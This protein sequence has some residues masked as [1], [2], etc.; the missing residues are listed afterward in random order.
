MIHL[1][2]LKDTLPM[3]IPQQSLE[4]VVQ[5]FQ[6]NNI[7]VFAQSL[8]NP[9][10]A[11]L[12]SR[13]WFQ[14]LY[15]TDREPSW[16]TIYLPNQRT[17]LINCSPLKAATRSRTQNEERISLRFTHD[18]VHLT[19]S[20][21]IEMDRAFDLLTARFKKYDLFHV[22]KGS[23]AEVAIRH[24][25]I[26]AV[27]Y[28]LQTNLATIFTQT[29]GDH[30]K[31]EYPTSV[32]FPTQV[33]D[34]LE[35]DG[36]YT[37]PRGDWPWVYF[38]KKDTIQLVFN[39]ILRRQSPTGNVDVPCTGITTQNGIN[40]ALELYKPSMEN[41]FRHLLQLADENAHQKPVQ[42]GEK[43]NHD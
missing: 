32:R 17:V 21:E 7:K 13:E 42:R 12:P 10:V 25:F 24:K 1:P 23:S 4:L 22:G 9:H 20:N 26:E 43:R 16:L 18:W 15:F 39:M 34:L 2:Y 35:K 36:R 31:L 5:D 19:D 41:I 40:L 30:L 29:R 28:N 27:Q 37:S 8:K 3:S 33:F 14:Q 38:L 11:P 6:T